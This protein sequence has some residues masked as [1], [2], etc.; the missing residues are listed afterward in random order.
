MTEL[1]NKLCSASMHVLFHR[2]I[3]LFYFSL[4]IIPTI[5]PHVI[6]VYALF[7][8]VYFTA[9]FPYVI[10]II[11]LIRGLTLPGA[12]VGLL[13]YLTPDFHRLA[14]A[15]VPTRTSARTSAHTHTHTHI[16]GTHPAR[17]RRGPPLLHHPGLPP[18]RGRT[19]TLY[20]VLDSRQLRFW[21]IHL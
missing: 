1:N 19:G 21:F 20:V 4:C 15:Q 12:G 17:R 16:P 3:S 11:L 6:L 10:L 14:D 8:V 7:Q 9:I 5:F 2:D 18:S 13:Y